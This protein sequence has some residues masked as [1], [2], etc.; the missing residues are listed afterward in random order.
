MIEKQQDKSKTPR[1]IISCAHPEAGHP[2]SPLSGAMAA[3]RMRSKRVEMD[4]ESSSDSDEEYTV[5]SALEDWHYGKSEQTITN[6]TNRVKQF[7]RFL[8]AKY[9]KTLEKAKRKHLK[10]YFTMLN[11]TCSQIR[12]DLCILR[13]MYRHFVKVGLCKK[14]PTHRFKVAQQLPA[15]QSRD[16]SSEQVRKLFAEAQKKRSKVTFAILQVLTYAGIRIGACASLLNKDVVRRIDDKNVEHYSLRVL[17][18]KG[19]KSRCIPLKQSIGKSLHA[20]AAIQAKKSVFLFPGRKANAPLTRCA[21]HQ[22]LKT[23]AKRAGLPHVSAHWLVSTL[24]SSTTLR[25]N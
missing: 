7:E 9:N 17:K 11:K 15:K 3:S 21:V 19:N 23:I 20:F 8:A 1:L 16:L 5:Q 22:R 25:I 10:A 24:L 12:P 13:S 6:Y 18:G 4:E 2:R 14:D